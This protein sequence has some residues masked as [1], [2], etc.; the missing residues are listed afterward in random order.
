MQKL[1][2]ARETAYLALLA[3]E[4][5]GTWSDQYLSHAILRNKLDP[6]D[7]AL[8]LRIT[9]GVLQNL[10]LCDYYLRKFSSV[11]PE[12]MEPSV[13][14]VLRLGVYQ[15][16][17]MDKIP[18]SAAVNEAVKLIR[19]H[20][21][22]A[23]GLVNAVLRAV[24]RSAE[25]L[26]EPDFPSTEESLS[27]RYSHPLWFV[28]EM[29]GRLG[30]DGARELLKANNELVPIFLQVNRTQS[31][32]ETV[33]AVLKAEGVEAF[34]HPW[35]PDCLVCSGIGS[36]ERLSAW[37]DGSL[38]IQDPSS[39][40]AVLAAGPQPGMTVLDA[41]AAPGG[42]S[43]AA[44]V[45]M[46][47]IGEITSCDIH[48]KKVKQ[49]R[50]GADRLKLR[51][52]SAMIMDG[53]VRNEEWR[54]KFSLVIADVPCSGLGTIRKKPDIR[55]KDPNSLLSLPALQY[56]LIENLSSY[57]RPGGVLLY[58]TCTVLARENEEVV[59]QFI[60]NHPEFSPEAFVLPGPV[61]TVFEGMLTLWPHLYGTDGFFIAKLRK[62]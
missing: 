41:C 6:R 21:E 28:R 22:R 10:Y 50:E 24:A 17:F 42:K 14:S 46:G 1:P 55:Y 36:L 18:H 56:E 57:V 9:D 51:N 5:S 37:K 25:K 49:I 7:A 26:P 34:V 30:E 54:D 53:R 59:A 33:L 45:M 31:D 40:C 15:I 62:H 44:S 52:I 60:R 38:Y 12:R 32:L 3:W 29:I 16:V 11:P 8:A 20:A 27:I 23:T 35:L 39:K 48:A 13:R 2:D 58:S 4:K 47:G 19:K 61:G 43:F